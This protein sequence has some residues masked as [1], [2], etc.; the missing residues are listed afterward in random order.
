LGSLP[1]DYN[2][3]L[4]V[5]KRGK[6]GRHPIILPLTA[7]RHECSA[8]RTKKKAIFFCCRHTPCG[9]VTVASFHATFHCRNKNFHLL[10]GVLLFDN[11]PAGIEV[12]RHDYGWTDEEPSSPIHAWQEASFTAS[13]PPGLI[14]SSTRPLILSCPCKPRA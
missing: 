13:S 4:C 8:V 14:N 11:S 1:S 9:R 10:K 3:N 6:E 5:K 7:E 2:G 12:C